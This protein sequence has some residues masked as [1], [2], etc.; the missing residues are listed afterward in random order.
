MGSR[1]CLNV[2]GMVSESSHNVQ[3]DSDRDALTARHELSQ[4]QSTSSAV[5]PRTP[6]SGSQRWPI[7]VFSQ[8]S[9][10]EADEHGRLSEYELM[11][12]R[13]MKADV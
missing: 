3:A 2:R 13:A 4:G 6:A 5:T 9:M 8:C 12:L 7:T 11:E 1:L 10:N